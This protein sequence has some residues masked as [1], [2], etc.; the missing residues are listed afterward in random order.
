MTLN[1]MIN[2]NGDSLYYFK[3]RQMCYEASHMSLHSPQLCAVRIRDEILLD[4]QSTAQSLNQ[5]R[6]VQI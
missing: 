6:K 2:E 1:R 3:R 4:A 5:D